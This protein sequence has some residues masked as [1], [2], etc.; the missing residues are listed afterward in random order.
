MQRLAMAALRLRRP[1]I[2]SCLRVPQGQH[3]REVVAAHAHARDTL[4]DAA[5]DIDLQRVSDLKKGL[6]YEALHGF[7]NVKVRASAP[8]VVSCS[9]LS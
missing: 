5:K 1:T 4:R 6:T 2:A 3:R 8:P 9:S 7:S